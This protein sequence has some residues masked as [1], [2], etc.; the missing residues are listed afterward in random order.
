MSTVITQRLGSIFR[1][2]RLRTIVFL[3]GSYKAYTTYNTY[4]ILN[5]PFSADQHRPGQTILD[6]DLDTVQIV[7]RET[8]TPFSSAEEIRLQRLIATLEDAKHD[9]RV[10]GLVVRG[11]GGLRGVGLAEIAE[12]RDV[13][14]EFS[15]GWGGKQT[16]LHVPEGLGGAGNGTIPMYFASAF[17]SVHVQPTSGIIIPGLS[18]AT[19][20]FKKMLDNVGVRAKKVARKEFKTAVNGL[21]EEKFTDAHR[22]STEA[23]LKAIMDA[24]VKG[25]AEG[26]G[27][28]ESKVREVIDMAI[29]S[30]QE[31]KNCGILD[32]A[33]YRDELPR[34]MREM[35]TNA[36]KNRHEKRKEAEEEW[37]SAMNELKSV[38]IKG[39]SN[40]IWA[41]GDI[42]NYLSRFETATAAA[43]SFAN[44]QEAWK[45]EAIDAEIR[46][47]NAHIH[48]LD[49]CPWE[50]VQGT[51]EEPFSAYHKITNI[52]SILETE[53]R[54]CLDAVK[55]LTECPPLLESLREE[56]ENE[57]V[58]KVNEKKSMSLI[59]NS[60]S[61]WR[62]KCLIARMVGTI[63]DAED[64][65][66]NV[67]KS[68]DQISEAT[69]HQN[70]FQPIIFLAGVMDDLRVRTVV[71]VVDSENS[72]SP[73]DGE[74]S[75][76]E[77]TNASEIEPEMQSKKARYLK[78]VRFS[79][80]IDLLNSEKRA[81][82][83]RSRGFIRLQS[84][85]P[86]QTLPGAVD[87]SERQALLRLQLAGYPFA[88]W[89]MG[90]PKGGVVAVITINGPISDD[91][92][93][94][95]R[96]ALR[97]ADKDPQI[98]AIVLRVDSPGGSATASDLISRAV[99]VAKKPVVASMGSIC[100]SGGYF[101]SAPCDKVFASDVTI[102]GSIGVIFSAFNTAGLFEKIGITSDSV[103]SGR[104]SKYF[105]AQGSITE[106]SDEFA[107]RIDTLI[108]NFYKDFVSVVAR[109]RG[110][111]F[112]RAEKI[113]RGRVWAGSDARALGLV[114]EIGGLKEAV[115][116]AAELA[117]LPPDGK[118]AAVNYPTM[119]MLLQDAAR[120]NGLIPSDLD[121]EGD[122]SV[123]E[124]KRRWFFS[125]A[126][127]EHDQ[128]DEPDAQSAPDSV[129][130]TLLSQLFG[131]YKTWRQFAMC[132]LLKSLDNLLL[133]SPSSM[134][135]EV[136]QMLL[137]RVINVMERDR[138]ASI[139]YD[140]LER[141][142]ATAGRPAA[143][144]PHIRLDD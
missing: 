124:R 77:K 90:L 79:D 4:S 13:I 96:A 28:E 30:P 130:T 87:Y 103:E 47:L 17:D 50:E 36:E 129:S 19:L 15:T 98:K 48:W 136:I 83:D 104:F 105:G 49:T 116:A 84:K 55:A 42:L 59:R 82:M 54:L 27:I 111:E 12:L 139:V 32:D 6:L 44:T 91:T 80:Y 143:I 11:L 75:F 118:I 25:T 71:K 138:S 126:T 64:S 3:L 94:I 43:L 88:P 117:S 38:W 65:L 120:R 127:E 53:R 93:D 81:V 92:A 131:E 39:G 9:P 18:A 21:T 85:D 107:K 74:T 58:L 109:G 40:D 31:A 135:S 29:M 102:T 63:L 128:S 122:E 1:N 114:D 119:A 125:R 72:N 34:A 14:R 24:I 108:D 97:R 132:S 123:T 16:M 37:M 10:V 7:T 20:F 26:R 69:L 95:T 134:T 23:L 137:G 112:E 141:N 144:A 78:H 142:Q 73:L 100:A 110:M 61:M 140:E 56:A 45:K 68:G 70:P 67:L 89:R 5:K 57:M 101:I 86:Y 2:R 99:E 33:L 76:V 121:E 51:E 62:A 113:A 106:W 35:I 41:G 133:S 8:Y 46:A 66:K 22:E 60:R 52:S 115:K